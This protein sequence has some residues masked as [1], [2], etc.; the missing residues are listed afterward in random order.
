[1]SECKLEVSPVGGLG[2]DGVI[3]R[4]SLLGLHVFVPPLACPD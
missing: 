4:S 1:L 2:L 3:Q